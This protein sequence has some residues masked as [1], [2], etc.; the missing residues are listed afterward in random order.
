MERRGTR[1]DTC[2][3]KKKRKKKEKTSEERRILPF[4]S[5]DTLTTLTLTNK[6]KARA[7]I[8]A[9]TGDTQKKKRGTS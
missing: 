2:S 8:G 1:D 5:S 3:L 6:R 9:S 7:A 4:D